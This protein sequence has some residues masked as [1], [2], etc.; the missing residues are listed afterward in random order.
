MICEFKPKQQNMFMWV[1]TI[2]D[3]NDLT[4]CSHCF[5]YSGVVCK[6]LLCVWIFSVVN[7]SFFYWINVTPLSRLLPSKVFCTSTVT[8]PCFGFFNNKF[9]IQLFVFS[10]FR[11]ACNVL[12]L[13]C[14]TS[15]LL[16]AETCRVM[17]VIHR[18]RSL[19]PLS[20]KDLPSP[21]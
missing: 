4:V 3:T 14:Q 19:H 18:I 7:M 20:W 13:I 12:L 5:I 2:L 16:I 6:L 21:R 9:F 15:D 8:R 11:L 10:R 17:K 1:R